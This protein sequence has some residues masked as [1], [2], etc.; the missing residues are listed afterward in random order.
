METTR[1]SMSK[2]QREELAG[3]VSAAPAIFRAALFTAAV[4]TVAL[5]LYA[6]IRPALRDM[7]DSHLTWLVPSVAFAW[8]LYRASG[9]WTGGSVLRAAVRR[10]LEQG[11]V[12]V[13]RIRAIDAVEVLEQ[14][15]EG[16][17]FFVLDDTGVVILFRGQ[18]LEGPKRKGFPW[19]L[20]DVIETPESKRFLRV[21][22]A[23]EP[24]EPS[25]RHASFP[26]PE[27]AEWIPIRR[28]WGIV[29]LDFEAVKQGRGIS[30]PRP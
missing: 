28:E 23:G 11:E 22:S 24:L 18:Y 3:Y 15:D 25:V 1:R 6:T 5:A 4:G 2:R 16:P 27:L 9:R 29:D 19:M 30:K 10:D 13:H 7:V 14:E 21:E 8:W 20:I 12:A 26:W 17:S